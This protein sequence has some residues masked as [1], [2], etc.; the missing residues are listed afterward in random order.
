V[1]P[2]FDANRL[3]EALKL[4]QEVIDEHPAV[5]E[6]QTLYASL[7]ARSA[8]VQPFAPDP[9]TERQFERVENGINKLQQSIA[10]HQGLV[11]RFPEIPLYGI[12]LL[13][14]KVQLVEYTTQF[15]RPE[16]AK[17]S[18]ADATALAEKMLQS[19][20]ARQ[21]AI[22]AILERLRERKIA[23]ENRPE[24]EKP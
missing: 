1:H 21:P 23:L 16:K 13:Q 20:A 6:Y 19:G 4:I 14:T 22:R 7:L 8:W 5:P 3:E 18:L 2:A 11:D 15:R 12:N 24:P 10:I 9:P 17:Q